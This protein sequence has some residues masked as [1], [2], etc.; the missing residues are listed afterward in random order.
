MSNASRTT[1]VTAPSMDY[2]N[3]CMTW[4]NSNDLRP[5]HEYLDGERA[6]AVARGMQ[7]A[8]AVL[9]SKIGTSLG[10]LLADALTMN[11]G[12]RLHRRLGRAQEEGRIRDMLEDYLKEQEENVDFEPTLSCGV[13][14]AIN[15]KPLIRKRG[16]VSAF[17]YTCNRPR[18]DPRSF[19]S[20]VVSD[21][22]GNDWI[23]VL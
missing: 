13:P 20:I 19:S 5:C 4:E 16:F 15:G 1:Y 7:I 12:T 18:P 6:L 10:T 14:E 23:R 17:P 22:G 8:A 21:C 9:A 2:S 11:R 3:A